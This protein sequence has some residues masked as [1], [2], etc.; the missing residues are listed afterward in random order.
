MLD[1]GCQVLNVMFGLKY[2][3]VALLLLMTVMLI[4]SGF[5]IRNV[6]RGALK[7]SVY[8][9]LVTAA[10]MLLVYI[11]AVIA[12]SEDAALLFY[13]IFYVIVAVM[14]FCLALYMQTYTRVLSHVR[15]L[16]WIVMAGIVADAVFMVLNVRY[17]NVFTCIRAVDNQG[18][19]FYNVSSRGNLYLIH[20]AVCYVLTFFSLSALIYRLVKSPKIFRA[21]YKTILVSMFVTLIVNA[22]YLNFGKNFDFSL[23]C[24]ALFGIAIIYFSFYHIPRGLVESLLAFVVKNME[25]GIVCFDINGKCIYA[26]EVA[27]E[28]FGVDE[29]W[30]VIEQYYRT[31]MNQRALSEVDDCSWDA[32]FEINGEKRYF[33]A[34]FKKLYDDSRTIGSFYLM[35]DNT[36]D[37][38]RLE[39]EHYRATHDELT[40]LYNE[41][42]FYDRV[43]RLLEDNP[44]TEYNIVC[45][46]IKDFKIVN[47]I[48]GYDKGNEMLIRIAEGFRL[49]VQEGAIYGRL[50]ADKFAI[51]IPRERFVEETFVSYVSKIERIVG[52]ETF[53]VKMYV[54]VYENVDRSLDISMM[55]DRVK[56]AIQSVKGKYDGT[57]VYYDDH[58]RERALEEQ[59]IVSEFN[60]AIGSGQFQIYIQP[61]V[62]VDG[63][64][65]G[66]EAL[67]RWAHPQRGMISDR[68]SV[69]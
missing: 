55:C 38:R 56:L 3:F 25:D 31:R 16:R 21:K 27:C 39:A 58:L 34:Y 28:L 9:L 13:G 14:L 6:P 44:H 10:V 12:N 40:G 50:S 37:I 2:I 65:H 24:Y 4:V 29:D 45:S 61:Q 1:I 8:S 68:K 47:D 42:Y 5:I 18:N 17:K 63:V 23:F 53:R 7:S 41:E 69:V 22:L 26:N 15:W 52:T 32:S 57:I 67:V 51:C 66:G 36:D 33:G 20:M 60:E 59:Q 62:S 46:D 49:A 54:G 30:T 64:V 35:H 11:M 43:K 48:Y 19:S